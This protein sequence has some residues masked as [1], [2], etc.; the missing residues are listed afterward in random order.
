[1]AS[2]N[3][4]Y[5]D[6]FSHSPAAAHQHETLSRL[7]LCPEQQCRRRAL[8]LFDSSLEQPQA[9][10]QPAINSFGWFDAG[11]GVPGHLRD[12]HLPSFDSRRSAPRGEATE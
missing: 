9:G 10:D 12:S 6:H 11:E 5:D 7:L 2:A 8:A 3:R 4:V 1:M